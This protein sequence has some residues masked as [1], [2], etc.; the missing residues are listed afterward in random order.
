[1]WR[2]RAP[3]SSETERIRLA[4]ADG[5]LAEALA[6]RIGDEIVVL[7]TDA[8]DAGDVEAR[9]ERDDVAGAERFGGVADEEGRFGGRQAEAVT[10]VMGKMLGDAGLFGHAAHRL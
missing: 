8:A 6:G 2:R 7:D 5:M 10:G 3:A 1:M 9:L 4:Q